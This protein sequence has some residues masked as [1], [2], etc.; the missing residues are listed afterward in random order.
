MSDGI[1][2]RNAVRRSIERVCLEAIQ[3]LDGEID[4]VRCKRF[5]ERLQPLDPALPFIAGPA[6]SRQQTHRG[7]ERSDE[8]TGAKFR[9]Y[10][11]AVFEE[12][13]GPRTYTRVVGDETRVARKSRT[14]D[15]LQTKTL[16]VTTDR[17][18]RKPGEIKACD[19]NTV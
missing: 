3:R 7:Q 1:T 19:L 16:G 18:S 6:S 14:E 8:Y 11:Y 9:R 5:P 4:V 10:L 13:C 2:E 17:S 12:G 15:R